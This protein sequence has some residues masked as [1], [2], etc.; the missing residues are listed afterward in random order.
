MGVLIGHSSISEKGTVNGTKGDSTKKEVCTREWY[1]GTWGFL[2]IHPDA[3]V[4]EA[5]ATEV[6]AGCANDHIGYGQSDRNTL[7]TEAA[8]VDYK[9]SKITVDNNCDCSSFMNVVAKGAGV[10]DY[11]SNGWITST[12]K[13]RMKADG[14]LILE[15][16][17]YL[18]NSKYCVRGGIYVRESYHTVMGLSDGAYASATLAAAGAA[19]SS[20][21]SS[22]S[23]S[24]ASESKMSVKEFQ[25]WLNTNYGDEIKAC[26]KCGE[27]K[28]DEDNDFGSK[29]LA[30]AVVAYQVECNAQFNAGLAEDGAFGSLSKE[31][32]NK[33]L[34]EKGDTG[35][36]VYIVQGLL[37]CK[38]FYDDELD[39]KAGSITST[40]IINYQASV[41]LDDD[42]QC[43]K[44][45]Y[46]KLMN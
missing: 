7:N 34:V 24:T 44:N 1:Y 19:V 30:G 28:L 3:A 8:K 42:G 20:S 15:D 16:A 6:E 13:S 25:A 21:S 41:G 5:M 33:A 43:G 29:T 23:S 35:A 26:E 45:T 37:H 2:A 31:Y 14:F 32:G 27:A 40:G 18:T 36:F 46:Y 39:G 4:R 10:S 11:T 12:M 17:A 9:L 22:S 38:G